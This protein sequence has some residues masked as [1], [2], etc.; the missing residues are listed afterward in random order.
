MCIT[1]VQ[2]QRIKDQYDL[3]LDV[4]FIGCG[5]GGAVM[6]LCPANLGPDDPDAAVLEEWLV[7]LS[8]AQEEGEDEFARAIVQ[9]RAAGPDVRPHECTAECRE[10]FGCFGKF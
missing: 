8:E 4:E 6:D 2:A 7:Y 10:S 1:D 9:Y 5:L 3:S